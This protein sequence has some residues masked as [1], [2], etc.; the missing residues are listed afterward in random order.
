MRVRIGIKDIG[1]RKLAYR[2]DDI[3]CRSGAPQLVGRWHDGLLFSSQIETL[4]V[5]QSWQAEIGGICPYLVCFAAWKARYTKGI[6]QAKT[7]VDFRVD[8]K[9]AALGYTHPGK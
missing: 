5:K 3:V 9:L 6:A 1:N 2:Q 7:L 4:P 8:P